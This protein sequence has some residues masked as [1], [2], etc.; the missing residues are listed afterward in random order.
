MPIG[1]MFSM[2]QTMMQLSA[3]SRTT[4]ISYSFHPSSDSSTR[5]SPMGEK[6]R[7]CLTAST[8]SARVPGDPPP[9]AP[10]GKGG[11]TNRGKAD[12]IERGE[13]LLDRHHD[14]AAGGLESD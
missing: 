7:P 4:S 2:E 12:P 8:S 1:S 3:W 10:K 11:G 13:S 5:T 9:S 6:A 14:L